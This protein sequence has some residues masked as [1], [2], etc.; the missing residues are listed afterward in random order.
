MYINNVVTSLISDLNNKGSIFMW[1]IF[2]PLL[3]RH[4]FEACGTV[5]CDRKGFT[6][7]F[8]SEKPAKGP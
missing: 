2:I 4:G 5:R 8:K 6:D 3:H 7:K 1:T